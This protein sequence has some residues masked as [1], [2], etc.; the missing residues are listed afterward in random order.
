MAAIS[1]RFRYDIDTALTSYSRE[2]KKEMFKR[3]GR[4]RAVRWRA[5]TVA[6]CAV[7]FFPENPL[8]TNPSADR[9]SSNLTRRRR[10]AGG[11]WNISFCTRKSH[12]PS[13]MVFHGNPWIPWNSVD[14]MDSKPLNSMDFRQFLGIRMDGID[15]ILE[16]AC[17]GTPKRILSVE[18]L[19]NVGDRISKWTLWRLDWRR[20]P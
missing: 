14:P 13:T 7:F 10:Y 2:S 9:A 5:V 17:K 18:T 8:T 6:A 11:E 15:G 16:F 20:G 19:N 3:R 1:I 12:S 4:P